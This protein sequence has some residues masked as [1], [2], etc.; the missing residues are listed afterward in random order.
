MAAARRSP[1]VLALT[2]GAFAAACLAEALVRLRGF[3]GATHLVGIGL[4][5]VSWWLALT[6]AVSRVIQE[7]PFRWFTT[8][9]PITG[10]LL[11]LIG[12]VAIASG[13]PEVGETP[14]SFGFLL[15]VVIVIMTPV[16]ASKRQMRWKSGLTAWSLLLHQAAISLAGLSGIV[17]GTYGD[18]SRADELVFFGVIPPLLAL[19]VAAAV[20]PGQARTQR[21]VAVMLGLIAV[22]AVLFSTSDGGP[23]LLLAIAVFAGLMVVVDAIGRTPSERPG[24]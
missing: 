8:L 13:R 22:P 11:V 2:V 9:V 15:I 16:A 24:S 6:G 12:E 19:L 5:Y 18:E 20:A 14:S 23:G 17:F 10:G 4:L 21:L 7:R 3:P 1:L